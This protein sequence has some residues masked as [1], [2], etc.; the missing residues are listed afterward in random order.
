MESVK[1][2]ELGYAEQ[3][4]L[5]KRTKQVFS[6]QIKKVPF[7][8][9]VD[10]QFIKS[11]K[12][13]IVK[14]VL[15]YVPGIACALLDIAM[16]SLSDQVSEQFVTNWGPLY[17]LAFLVLFVGCGIFIWI[18]IDKTLQLIRSFQNLKSAR[19]IAFLNGEKVVSKNDIDFLNKVLADTV[20]EEDTWPRNRSV[21]IEDERI[22]MIVE[23]FKTKD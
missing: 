11:L 10:R 21:L 18:A 17:V 4:A 15:F 16:Y 5:V 2:K 22:N 19:A 13:S 14:A 3:K 7:E 20:Q 6:D 23:S 12:L 8:E 1:L 9:A